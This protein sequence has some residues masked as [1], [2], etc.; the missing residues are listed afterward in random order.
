[1]SLIPKHISF[2]RLADLV[3]GRLSA[4][5][6]RDERAHLDACARCSEQA[7]Q[8]GHV[9]QLMRADTSQDAP[10]DA[11]FNAVGMFRARPSAVAAPNLLRRIVAALSFDSNAL[12]P[13]F[14][15][16]SGQSAPARQLLFNAGDF[17]IDL[18]LASNSEGWTVSGQVLGR[19][20]GGEVS[21]GETGQAARSSAALN[22]LCEFTLPPV[23]EGS[24][25][26][27]LRLGETEIEIPGLSLR[28]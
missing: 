9:T 3:E 15:V 25:A 7:A 27:R 17:D 14:G 22:D 23:P 8:L 6:A 5:E 12:A 11:I 21:L 20:E 2:A 13:A 19:C 10:R 16:R 4:D 1:M 18:R 28:A 26:L 24:Y